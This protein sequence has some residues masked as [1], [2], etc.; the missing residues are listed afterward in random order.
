MGAGNMVKIQA[1]L[2]GDSFGITAT[3]EE[4]EYVRKAMQIVVEKVTETLNK[5]KET[6]DIKVRMRIVFFV[7]IQYVSLYMKER[8]GGKMMEK[9]DELNEKIEAY[10]EDK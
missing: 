8:D 3:P 2:F 6:D 7:A 5:R 4:E 10:L 9:I 1:S